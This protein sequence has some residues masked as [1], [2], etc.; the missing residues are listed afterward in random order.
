M[1]HEEN[2][3]LIETTQDELDAIVRKHSMF[4]SARVGGARAVL[5]RHNLS[6]LNISGLDLSYADMTGVSLN[7]AN[8]SGAMLDYCN[9]F[10]ADMRFCN[11]QGAHL[12]R[13][14]L[15]GA[16]LRGANLIAADLAGADLREGM[17]A[18][19]EADG[20]IVP[21]H[22][23]WP[24]SEAGGADFSG[25]N[26]TDA[27]LSGAVAVGTKFSDTTMCGCK[28][29]RARLEGSDFS[30]ANLEG[31]DLSQC[32]LTR[33]N[34]RGAVLVNAALNIA[35]LQQA[36]LLNAMTNLP[37]GPTA[38]DLSESLE[39]LLRKHTAWVSSDGTLGKQL[40]ISNH[41]MRGTK[42][43]AY[44]HLALV[45]A[46]GAI[47]YGL[48]L[49]ESQMQAAFLSNSDMRHVSAFKA[50]FRGVDMVG[51]RLT[52]ADL[53]DAHFEPLISPQGRT[54]TSN[55]TNANLRY[56]NLSG[57][58]LRQVN[59]NN[60]DLSYANLEGADLTDSDLTFTIIE[61]TRFDAE[62]KIMIAEMLKD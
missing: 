17:L 13:A 16:C 34:M 61:G 39:D 49:T 43:F 28:I 18:G 35:S 21:L 32:D 6:G 23:D 40:D 46:E 1:D 51:T 14:D 29:V 60:T 38:K 19:T 41:D 55:L 30:G 12:M 26:L 53:R 56:A 22:K 37:L 54:I 8:A 42:I 52:N 10:G 25:A 5:S 50:D 27:R 2:S 31:A 45:N 36:N 57:A 44:A 20:D 11:L 62:Q 24:A 58:R 9:F 3:R 47:L 48:D 4:L 15:R 7:R 59:L 33:V